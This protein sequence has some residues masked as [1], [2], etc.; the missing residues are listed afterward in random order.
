MN[1]IISAIMKF[2][3]TALLFIGIASATLMMSS[4][5]DD[6]ADNAAD[7]IAVA[8]SNHWPEGVEAAAVTSATVSMRELN[9]GQ[10]F[11]VNPLSSDLATLPIGVYD[12]TGTATVTCTVPASGEDGSAPSAIEKN[13]R[14]TGSSVTVSNPVQLTLDWFFSNPGGT[15]VFSEIY[16]CGSPNATATGGLRDT[17]LRITNNTGETIWADGLGIAE[18]AFVN[19]RASMYEILTPANDRN[20]N[21]T[22]GTIWVIPGSGKDYPIAPGESIK[23][24][25][26][27]IDWSAQV[28]GAL[29]HLDADFEWHDDHAQDTDNP[30]VTNLD[31]W[32][33]YSNT[34]WIISNQCNRSYAL[35]K[36]PAGM[37]ADEY[38]ATCHGGY[39]YIHTIG[40]HMH[41]D[42]AYLIPN[43]WILDGVNLGND[44]TYVY[45]ALADGIDISYAS[46]STIDKDPNRFGKVFRRKTAVTHPDGRTELQDTNDSRTDFTLVKL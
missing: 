3:N 12:Y 11:T 43:D 20:V 34:I 9:T 41:N 38:L 39:D 4:C 29:N 44:V 30:S 33:S 19:A 14:V 27:A 8:F 18:S 24:A 37:T 2:H 1:K 21:F 15:L 35:V 10:T 25:D 42:K 17:Y 22:A 28:P 31:K 26:Q 7:S 5:V 16:A 36:Y 45:G 13:M 46:I 23:I 32:Y 6:D 40:T